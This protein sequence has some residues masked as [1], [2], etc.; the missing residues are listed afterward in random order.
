MFHAFSWSEFRWIFGS[1]NQNSGNTIRH[2][3]YSI[4][5]FTAVSFSTSQYVFILLS[6]NKGLIRKYIFLISVLNEHPK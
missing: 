1:K 2:V 3:T 4:Y 6:G 5:I